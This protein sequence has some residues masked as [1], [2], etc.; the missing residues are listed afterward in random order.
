M[1]LYT[2]VVLCSVRILGAAVV[3]AAAKFRDLVAPN[4]DIH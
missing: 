1:F 3:A 2:L 4:R